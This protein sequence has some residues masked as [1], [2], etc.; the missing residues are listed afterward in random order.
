MRMAYALELRGVSKRFVVGTATCLGSVDVLRHV[1]LYVSAGE[2]LAVVGNAGAGKS[3]LLLCAAGLLKPDRGDVT[4]YGEADRGVACE[5]SSYYFA[6]SRSTRPVRV[7]N[8]AP[9]VHLVDGPEAL[10]LATASRT[11]AWIDRRC[12]AGDAVVISLRS[13]ETAQLLVNRMLTL[14][15][16]RIYS[17]ERAPLV[18][19]VAEALRA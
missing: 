11:K 2:A 6:G 14:R 17:D 9:H 4:W 10:S 16:G 13:A 5:R 12:A 7:A 15:A 3:T 18:A 1:D 8:D 19:R